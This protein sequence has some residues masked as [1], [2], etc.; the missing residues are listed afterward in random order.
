M[1][2]A[3]GSSCTESLLSTNVQ[4]DTTIFALWLGTL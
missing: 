1:T 3:L 4:V 2:H